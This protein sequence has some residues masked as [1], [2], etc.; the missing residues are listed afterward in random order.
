MDVGNGL[1]SVQ[2]FE[3]TECN[4]LVDLMLSVLE[5]GGV[6]KTTCL[7][8]RATYSVKGCMNSDTLLA[9]GGNEVG[10]LRLQMIPVFCPTMQST[11]WRV[12]LAKKRRSDCFC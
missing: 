6:M 4:L 8:K 2:G 5:R 1:G 12:L 3:E 7:Q 10:D 11:A 9:I